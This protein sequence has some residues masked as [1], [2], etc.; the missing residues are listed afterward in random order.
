[1]KHAK[2]W[3]ILDYNASKNLHICVAFNITFFELAQ[4]LSDLYAINDSVFL[5]VFVKCK[6]LPP[7][8]MRLRDSVMAV[9]NTLP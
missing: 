1:M 2:I 9:V 8:S 3:W 6:R 5:S 4:H 7:A